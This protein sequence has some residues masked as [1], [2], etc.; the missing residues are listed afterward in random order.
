MSDHFVGLVLQRLS[1]FYLRDIPKHHS[2][3]DSLPTSQRE[4]NFT[5]FSSVFRNATHYRSRNT[6][7]LY[8]A[9]LKIESGAA[10]IPVRF[11][12]ITLK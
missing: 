11:C 9:V 5:D 10:T 7:E 8:V 3:Y 4:Q 2:A 12:L 6:N 1:P